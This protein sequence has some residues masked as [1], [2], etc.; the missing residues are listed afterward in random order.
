M[1][2][3]CRFVWAACASVVIL[4][5]VTLVPRIA[6]AEDIKVGTI[7][8]VGLG[9]LFL[10]AEKG[11]FKDEGL[12]AEIVFFDS[13]EPI[14]VA[15][16]GS[17][18]DFGVDGVSAGLYN[19]AGQGA[20]RLIAGSAS[21]HA[22]FRAQGYIVSNHA[23]DA[24][25]KSMKDFAG[26]S[27]GI[28]VVGSTQH[29]AINLLAEKYGY[30]MKGLKIVA[31]QSNVNI[32]SSVTG[33]QT[34]AGI[35]PQ[36]AALP[37]VNRGDAK[38][39][40]WVGDETPW[41]ISAVWTAKKTA[42]DRAKTVQAFL[43]AYRKGAQAYHDAFIGPGEVR[44]DGPTTGEAMAIIGKYTGLSLDLVKLG[45]GY[46]D[47][48]ARLNVADVLHQIAWFKSQGMIKSEIDG[49]AIIDRRYVVPLPEK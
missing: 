44:Q 31:L 45:I 3:V 10:S 28:P 13:G 49:N 15:V 26:R 22:G 33:G 20:L 14:A 2:P 35:L 11:Y 39:L 41:Q 34:D 8:G 17:A 42:D 9:A 37:V 36:A 30:D 29:Y 12:N 24:G 21:E 1:N 4:V 40:G 18:V 46:H 32:A 47:A 48:E 23:F 25:L 19:L 16:A 5:S 27:I 38:L 7:K 43:R 6:A